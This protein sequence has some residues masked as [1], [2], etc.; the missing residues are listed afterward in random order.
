MIKMPKRKGYQ[1]TLVRYRKKPKTQHKKKDYIKTASDVRKAVQQTA[2]SRAK[3][4]QL[5]F[6]VTT[7]PATQLSVSAIEFNEDASEFQARQSLKVTVGSLRFR[8]TLVVGDAS[9]LVRL[10]I[11]RSKNQTNAAFDPQSCFYNNPGG[12]SILGVFSQINTRNVDVVY[13]KTWIMQDSTEAV[14]AVRPATYFIDENVSIRKTMMYN[15]TGSGVVTQPRNMTE[16]YMVAVSD[17]G[18][19]P[20]PSFRLACCTWFKNVD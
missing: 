6:S 16:Y 4:D 15:Q 20:N 1:S 2:P 14:P 10:L 17:S 7:T 12:A 9:N 8:G 11:V 3:L 13:D 19:L 5:S 18:V